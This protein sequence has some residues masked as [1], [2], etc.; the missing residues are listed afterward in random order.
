MN[1]NTSLSTMAFDN[2][3][4]SKTEK[5]NGKQETE[6]F[7]HFII[8]RS[9]VF[10]LFFFFRKISCRFSLHEI[11]PLRIKN[12]VL[13]ITL[14]FSQKQFPFQILPLNRFLVIFFLFASCC[15]Q[16]KKKREKTELE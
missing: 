6:M 7:Q 12:I 4:L 14:S 2:S 13:L 5:K 9:S 16:R 1:D 8:S 10:S 11:F 3:T 15:M